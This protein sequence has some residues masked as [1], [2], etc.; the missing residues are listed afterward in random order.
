MRPGASV[1]PHEPSCTSSTAPLRLSGLVCLQD[2]S[3]FLRPA[4]PLPPRSS[5]HPHSSSCLCLHR[6]FRCA[7]LS[8]TKG[9]SLLSA[10]AVSAGFVDA[11]QIGAR[12][13]GACPLRHAAP[14]GAVEVALWCASQRASRRVGAGRMRQHRQVA[15]RL[16]WAVR[17]SLCT[18]RLASHGSAAAASSSASAQKPGDTQRVSELPGLPRAGGLRCRCNHAN[19]AS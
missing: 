11:A 15:R 2:A 4:R 5:S 16:S 19:T 9:G 17:L 12:H 14:E 1:Q 10:D 8:S 13:P 7:A 18:S 6:I 3:R